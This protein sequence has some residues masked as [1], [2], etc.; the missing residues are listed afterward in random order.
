MA[1]MILGGEKLMGFLGFGGNNRRPLPQVFWTIQAYSMQIGMVLY[2]VL[3]QILNSYLVSG[4]F[5]VYLDD[6]EIF[7]KLKTGK[8][9]TTD[10]LLSS[11]QEAGLTMASS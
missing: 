2:F 11:L 7:S 1:W 9:P 5:E 6:Q 10:I 3:P 4:A 8:L